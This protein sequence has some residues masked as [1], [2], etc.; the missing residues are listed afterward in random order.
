GHRE[1]RETEPPYLCVLCVLCGSVCRSIGT[2]ALLVLLP[3]AAG[4][5]IVA[6]DLPALA[7][8]G[9]HVVAA[10][11]GFLGLGFRERGRGL[12]RVVEGQVAGKR[13]GATEAHAAE[14]GGGA[15]S[16]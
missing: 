2:V 12:G 16:G 13:A 14:P 6:A 1:H 11:L 8:D 5:G 10:A 15:R 7:L 9:L 4:A 3:A